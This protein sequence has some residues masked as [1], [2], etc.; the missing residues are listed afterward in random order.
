[1]N[2]AINSDTFRGTGDPASAIRAAADAGF[3]HLMWCHQWCTDFLYT[4]PELARIKELLTEN[5]MI[6][7]DVH[8]TAGSEKCWFSLDES[9]R[10]AGVLLVQNR[11]EMMQELSATGV[12]TMHGPFYRKS[13]P[14]NREDVSR[15]FDQVRKSLDDLMPVLDRYDR[16]I[17]IENLCGDT[18]ELL[19][20]LLN[21]Y[22]ANR[23]GITYDAGHGNYAE[24]PAWDFLKKWKDR[25]N[26]LH[27]HDNDGSGDQH[28]PP[29][30]GTV[31]WDALTQVLA[32]SAYNN[33]LCFELS[34][35]NTPFKHPEDPGNPPP[36][37]LMQFM[38][39]AYE[40]CVRVHKFY[41]FYRKKNISGK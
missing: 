5:D 26:A 31:D 40:R 18:W 30:Y 16:L 17:A 9:Q 38:T 34:M 14:E 8:G 41:E 4:A 20:K 2:I 11:L 23:V 12:L 25:V 28:Q 24:L 6:L 22:P 1:M 29:F 33:P 21:D 37:K 32:S 3:T 13:Q 27:L 36:E 10:Q 39:D 7:Q 19:E 35:R 15:Q